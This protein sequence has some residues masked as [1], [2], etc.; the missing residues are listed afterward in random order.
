MI[1]ETERLLIRQITINDKNLK[2]RKPRREPA[3]FASAVPEVDSIIA[4]YVK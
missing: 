2:K 1:L 4:K 3:N